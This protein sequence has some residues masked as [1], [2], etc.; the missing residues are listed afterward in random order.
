MSSSSLPSE[1]VASAQREATY[2]L[3]MLTLGPDVEVI[4]VVRTRLLRRGEGVKGDPVRVITQYWSREGALLAEHD[5][6]PTNA[7]ELSP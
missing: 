5:P 6:W 7:Q 2:G 4:E 3:G 1:S